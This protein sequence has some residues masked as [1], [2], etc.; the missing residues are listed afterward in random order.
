MHGYSRLGRSPP[1]PPPSRPPSPRFYH[2]RSKN[3]SVGGGVFRSGGGDAKLQSFVERLVY[4][5]ISAVYKR[6]G[7]LLFAPL[8]YISGMLLYM[9][10]LGFDVVVGSKV[11]GG[12]GG[13]GKAAPPGSVY[14]S[15]QVFEKLWSFMEAENN[16]SSSNAMTF[17]NSNSM[18]EV[19]TKFF[20]S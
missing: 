20:V 18:Y 3:T 13:G 16:G 9:R 6:R 7:V 15:P 14:R 8:L 10:G 5:L 12:G 2:G 1:S 11:G 19:E 4:L 17:K